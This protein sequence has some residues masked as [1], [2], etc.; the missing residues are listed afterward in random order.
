MESQQIE[1][2][3]HECYDT[4]ETLYPFIRVE[5]LLFFFLL[6]QKFTLDVSTSTRTKEEPPVEERTTPE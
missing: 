6:Y 2:N 5:G 4:Q 3:I 1:Y